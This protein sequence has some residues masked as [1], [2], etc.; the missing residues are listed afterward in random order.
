MVIHSKLASFGISA[1]AKRSSRAESNQASTND[2]EVKVEVKREPGIDECEE[3][4]H[5]EEKQD[6]RDGYNSGGVLEDD[7]DRRVLHAG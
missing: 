3:D 7:K 1:T 4:D 2:T 6:G 5:G